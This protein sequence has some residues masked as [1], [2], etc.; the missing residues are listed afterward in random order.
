MKCPF[1]LLLDAWEVGCGVEEFILLLRILD[2]S[3]YENTVNFIVDVL[4]EQLRAVESSSFWELD[5]CHDVLEKI[6]VHNPI[7]GR[8]EGD[9]GGDECSFILG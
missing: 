4:D 5:R 3:V 6:L 9:G 2:V 8:K 1:S 7:R